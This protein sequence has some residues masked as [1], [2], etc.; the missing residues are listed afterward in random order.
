MEGWSNGDGDGVAGGRSRRK[1]LV[2]EEKS[3]KKGRQKEAGKKLTSQ[4]NELAEDYSN[5]K[6]EGSA[7]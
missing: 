2:E 7:Q 4:G 6:K 1:T 5:R 3:E